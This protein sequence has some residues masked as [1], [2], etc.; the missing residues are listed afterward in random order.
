VSLFVRPISVSPAAVAFILAA[1]PSSSL[2]APS[3]ATLC[4]LGGGQEV[5]EDEEEDEEDE[6]DDNDDNDEEADGDRLIA[7]VRVLP[8]GLEGGCC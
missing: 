7:E 8:L 4:L 3:P 2:S 1:R 5:V 6:E